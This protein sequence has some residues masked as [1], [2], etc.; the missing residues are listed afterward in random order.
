M[1][2]SFFVT[3]HDCPSAVLCPCLTLQRE[4]EIENQRTTKTNTTETTVKNVVA[5]WEHIVHL[6][7]FLSECNKDRTAEAQLHSHYVLVLH[8]WTLWQQEADTKA[9]GEQ[10]DVPPYL[11]FQYYQQHRW[12]DVWLSLWRL[13]R[14]ERR[15]RRTWRM[16]VHVHRLRFHGMGTDEMTRRMWTCVWVRIDPSG[17]C[18][19]VCLSSSTGVIPSFQ[20]Q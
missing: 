14:K 17:V 12:R 6:C 3:H 5:N 7:C 9:I 16:A 4:Q 15:R 8:H 13:C 2:F 18:K 10:Q 11:H 19:W 20:V 1:F